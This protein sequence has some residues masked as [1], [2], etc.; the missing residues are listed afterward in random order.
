MNIIEIPI[1]VPITIPTTSPKSNPEI[2]SIFQTTNATLLD[3]EIILDS[4]S[5]MMDS[6][7]KLF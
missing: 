5:V 1:A 3:L 7:S 4:S 6:N 2:E